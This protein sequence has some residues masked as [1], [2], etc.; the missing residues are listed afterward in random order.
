MPRTLNKTGKWLNKYCV[1]RDADG[2]ITIIVNY[3][4]ET[5]EGE[6]IERSMTERVSGAFK[7]SLEDGFA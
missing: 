3:V 5:S 6:D 7:A 1:R 4:I 2:N